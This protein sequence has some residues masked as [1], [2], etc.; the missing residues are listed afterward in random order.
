MA[1]KDGI[2]KPRFVAA[3][4]VSTGQIA[5]AV[6]YMTGMILGYMWLDIIDIAEG[7]TANDIKGSNNFRMNVWAKM[8]NCCWIPREEFNF[9]SYERNIKP[10]GPSITF[11]RQLPKP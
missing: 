4:L 11:Q 3:K 8:E 1:R 2:F 5:V 9:E 7:V 10:D 6:E